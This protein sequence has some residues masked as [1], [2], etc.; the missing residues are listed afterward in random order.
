MSSETPTTPATP[1]R[2]AMMAIE[3]LKPAP[4]NPREI[5]KAALAGLAKSLAMFGLVEPIVFNET[6]GYIVG[7]H[8]RVKAL[9]ANGETAALVL[10]GKWTPMEEKALNVT[11]NNP[12][13]AG[14]FTRDALGRVLNDVKQ[15]GLFDDDQK[16]LRFDELENSADPAD[17][18]P[19]GLVASPDMACVA[20]DTR[21]ISL[22]FDSVRA[23]EFVAKVNALGTALGGDNL[24]DRV[25]LI[26]DKAHAEW[27]ETQPP[28]AGVA[29]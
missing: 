8:Q 10:I 22:F 5:D 17:R 3:D 14:H 26:V 16:Q 29:S 19:K 7:G 11:L 25:A 28:A 4:Y 12:L 20:A 23:A 18:G 2:L 9:K 21:M 13:I 27:A 1:F 6:T 15:A 24:T